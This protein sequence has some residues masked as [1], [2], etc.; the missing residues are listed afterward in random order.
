MTAVWLLASALT[1]T[2]T[3]LVRIDASNATNYRARAWTGAAWRNER[4]QIPFVVRTS[5][6]KSR[7]RRAERGKVNGLTPIDFAPLI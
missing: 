3:P 7:R 5:S 6:V 4:V 1:L 2:S